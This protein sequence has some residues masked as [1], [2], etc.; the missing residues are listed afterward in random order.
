[1]LC[2]LKK[3]GSVWEE[4]C[5]K[6]ELIVMCEEKCCSWKQMVCEQKNME[7]SY[8]K[9]V[10]LVQFMERLPWINLWIFY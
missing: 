2:F 7:I 5:V 8:V 6:G 3:K 10:S 9:Y 1:M 4:E